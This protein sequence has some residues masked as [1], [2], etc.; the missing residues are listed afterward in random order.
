MPRRLGKAPEIYTIPPHISFVDGLARGI[1]D[2]YGHDPLILSDILILLP[3][4]RAVRSLREAFLRHGGGRALI[5]PHMEPIGDVDED[6]LFLSGDLPQDTRGMDMAPPIPGPMRQMLLMT[7][8]DRWY[9]RRGEDRPDAA[10]CALLAQALGQFLDHVQTEGLD[11]RGLDKLVPEAYAAHWQQTLDFLKILTEHW[12]DILATTGYCDAAARRGDLLAGLRQKWLDHPPTHPIIAAGSTGSIPATA[13]LLAVV[14]RLPKGMVLLPGL[15]R[16]MD[17]DSWELLGDT[18]PQATMKHLLSVIGG[19]RE[20]VEDWPGAAEIAPERLARDHLLREVMRPAETTDQWRELD[21]DL[22]MAARNFMRLDAPGPREEAGMIALMLRDVLETE[23]RTA[24]LITPDRQ[25]ARRVAGELKR[26]DIL[27]DDSAGIPLANSRTGLFLR[28]TAQMVADK[29]SPVSLLSVLK[30]PLCAGGQAVGEFRRM[31]RLLEEKILRGPRPVGGCD[32]MALAVTENADLKDW[33]T[34]LADIIAPFEQVMA[35]AEGSFEELLISHVEMAERLCATSDRTGAARLWQGDAGEEAAKLIEGLNQAAPTLPHLKPE[36]YPALLE[37]FMSGLTVRPKYGQHPRL[38]I[39]SPLEARLQHTDL[40]ILAG[41]NE[42]TWPPEPQPDPWMSRPMRADFGLPSLERKIGLS[43]HDFVQAASGAKVVLTRAEKVEGTPTVKSRWLSRLDAIA[44]HMAKMTDMSHWLDWYSALDRPDRKVDITPP[45][46]TPP[47][48][49]RPRQLSVTRIE[50]WMQDPYSIYARH[51]LK[52][53]PLDP[54][55]A[56]PGA[57]DKGTIIHDALDEFMT[58][59]PEFLPDDAV[60]R[61]LDIGQKKFEKHLDR[62]QVRAFWWPRFVQVA[63]WFVDHEKTLR[64]SSKTVATEVSARQTFDLPGGAFT[65]TAKADRIDLLAD[66]SYSIIDYKT[67]QSPTARKLHAGYA[68][69]LPL[70]GLMAASGNFKDLAAAP[71]SD[72]SYWQL[73]GGATVAKI[74]AFNETSRAKMDVEAVISAAHDGL[75]R[76]VTSFDMPKTPYLN[77]PRPDNL[78]YGEYDHLART[79]EWQ[80]NDLSDS[81]PALA[82]GEETS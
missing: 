33:W 62:P 64:L 7:I 17:A 13:D 79:K 71:V 21:L 59:Y 23:G 25:L 32:G 4:R 43:A 41:L 75:V 50:K 10:Q 42:G 44:P 49:V 57:A 61:L 56:D 60:A 35:Q 70:E 5:L 16:H 14:A 8:I 69:Q 1:F 72:L 38:N 58:E 74:T 73:K 39:W 31:V 78:G 2:R 20:I 40:V 68:P 24:A 45:K 27:I 53:A 3:N 48:T 77:N 28:L 11:F 82:K 47:V 63:E 52:L 22:E 29:L 36:S 54:L 9:A 30:H 12:P 67:G 51:I 18:H 19:T 15:D 76:L 55:D 81:E 80:G 37:V 65:L 6:E 66:G 34:G 26:W 46:P